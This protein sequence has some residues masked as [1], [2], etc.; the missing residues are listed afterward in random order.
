MS[1]RPSV[2]FVDGHTWE[3]F[4]AM[5]GALRLNGVDIEHVVAVPDSGRVKFLQ[6]LDVPLY[7][8]PIRL[9]QPATSG[10]PPQIDLAA[11]AELLKSDSIVDVQAHDDLVPVLAQLDSPL[12]DPAKRVGS[13]I[14]PLV[15]SD[16]WVLAQ[17]LQKL[18]VPTPAVWQE[19]HSDS[20]PV[21]VKNPVGFAGVGVYVVHSQA[22]LEAAFAE[23]AV[24][25]PDVQPFCQQYL[26]AGLLD[27]CGVADK[28]ELLVQGCYIAKPSPSDPQ[29][30]SLLIEPIHHPVLE[31]LTRE[32][33]G[34]L[35][36]TGFFNLDWVIDDDGNPY[37]IDFNARIFGSWPAM[38]EAG[39]DFIGAYMYLL[40]LGPRPKESLPISGGNY[41]LLRFPFPKTQSVEQIKAEK[42]RSLAIIAARRR[43]LGPRWARV[44]RV[45]VELA[46]TAERVRL[47]RGN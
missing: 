10:R 40:G 42:A 30:P 41:G 29:G 45:K 20:F 33:I 17:T 46:A 44:S 22:E 3:A 47:R 6:Q 31:D 4:S 34:K 12:T 36:F 18:G 37:L 43:F 13:G 7:G 25:A 9:V 2:M 21:V 19:Q 35:G 5:V 23:L 8:K 1:G 26:G 24:D 32:V 28:G 14:D 11:L 38:Q 15:L 16:K 39:V 27:S